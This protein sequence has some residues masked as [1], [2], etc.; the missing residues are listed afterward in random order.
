MQSLKSMLWWIGGSLLVILSSIAL[1][2]YR[3]KKHDAIGSIAIG[4]IEAAH[5]PVIKQLQKDI[6]ADARDASA[7]VEDVINAKTEVA[8]RKEALKKV[9]SAVGL[10][11]SE[12]AQRL[13]RFSL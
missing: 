13:A 11:A 7:S 2:V 3:L 5:A 12:V 6:A 4:A 8:A 1:V 9:Y 10:S